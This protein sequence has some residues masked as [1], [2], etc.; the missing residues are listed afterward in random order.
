M[1]MQW[2]SCIEA[3]EAA[4]SAIERC[5]EDCL[6]ADDPE[7]LEECA[8]RA[9]DALDSVRIASVWMSR[10]SEHAPTMARICAQICEDCAAECDNHVAFHPFCGSCAEACRRAAMECRRGADES[11]RERISASAI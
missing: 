7:N 2:K 3:C 6:H 9:R 4:A 8:D 1:F 5:I 11:Y 10:D